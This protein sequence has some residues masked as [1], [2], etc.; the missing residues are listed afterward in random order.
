MCACAQSG[1]GGDDDNRHDDNNNIASII[2]QLRTCAQSAGS[3]EFGNASLEVLNCDSTQKQR[4]L[5]SRFLPY[6]WALGR[7][8]QKYLK[9]KSTWP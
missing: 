1:A 2:Q 3:F 7:L 4:F 9:S 6:M 5:L 8:A